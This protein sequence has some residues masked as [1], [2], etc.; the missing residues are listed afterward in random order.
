MRWE[1]FVG[2]EPGGKRHLGAQA[3]AH[4][5]T[6]TE[7]VAIL[8]GHDRTSPFRLR[9]ALAIATAEPEAP[10]SRGP[11][12]AASATGRPGQ[13]P[14]WQELRADAH[15]GGIDR[16]CP[17]CHSLVTCTMASVG[18]GMQT[19]HHAMRW[20]VASLHLWSPPLLP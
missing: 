10:R 14:G 11:G 19:C 3:P 18:C 13:A 9:V 12:T 17:L 16:Q 4:L 20:P 5:G 7:C 2:D 6:K 15:L 8:H 1:F